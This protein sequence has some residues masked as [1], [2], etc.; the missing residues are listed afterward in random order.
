M[1]TDDA[2]IAARIAATLPAA[3]WFADKGAAID[4]VA[5]HD[6]L[7]LPAPSGSGEPS[8]SLL[9]ADVHVSGGKRPHRYCLVVD[10]DGRDAASTPTFARWLLDTALAGG[11]HAAAAGTF[12]GHGEGRVAAS[13][14]AS[15]PPTVTPIGGDASNS[16]FIVGASDAAFVVKLFRLC[17]AG[18]QPEVEVGEFLAAC[19]WA[20]A[21]RLRGWL[22]YAT[23]DGES[24]AL[25]TVH[26][27][28]P[29]CTTAWD[30]VGRLLAAGGPAAAMS[31]N[32][33][34]RI[35]AIGG[36]TGEMHRVLASRPDIPAFAA[37]VPSSADR[38]AMATRMADH[39]AGVFALIESRL[40]NVT[41]S[42]A[43]RLRRLS[44]ARDTLLGRFAGLASLASDVPHIR[45]HGDYHLGQVLV[46]DDDRVFVID[47]EGE[48]GRPLV[49]RRA[50]ASAAKDVAGMCRSLDYA[51]RCAAAATGRPYRAED[52]RALEACFLDAYTTAAAGAAWWPADDSTA[53]ALLEVHR[54]DKAIYELAY[55]INNRPDWI[56]VP[57]AALEEILSTPAPSRV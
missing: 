32:L 21:P 39:A 22:E 9:L 54:L 53:A 45:V 49:D 27:L 48:P 55:E 17:R 8:L 37:R 18:I 2:A 5:T 56:E 26:D 57:L 24:T 35:A 20:G 30:R 1:P 25:A 6:Q 13:A 47:F 46:G 42:I 43:K 16:S 19:G 14:A 15:A 23:T 29:D 4:R 34:Q 11:R 28:A 41:P 33:L 51:V 12:A 38:L 50:K 7:A 44:A 40:P 3:R 52:A 10:A 36:L 31:T